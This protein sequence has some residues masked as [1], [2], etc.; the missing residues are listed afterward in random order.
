[1][2]GTFKED[3]IGKG[4]Y[5]YAVSWY[6]ECRPLLIDLI[7]KDNGGCQVVGGLKIFFMFLGPFF[8]FEF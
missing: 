5:S 2:T 4:D 8:H 1:M 6:N 3:I 7:S